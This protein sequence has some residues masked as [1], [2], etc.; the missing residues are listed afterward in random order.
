VKKNNSL[1]DRCIKFANT[2]KLST[3]ATVEF[4]TLVTDMYIAAING[5]SIAPDIDKEVEK[6]ENRCLDV[7]SR[8][9]TLRLDIFK[10]KKERKILSA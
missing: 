2:H 4:I 1:L 9:K 7:W 10:D 6:E 5:E 8:E 3:S